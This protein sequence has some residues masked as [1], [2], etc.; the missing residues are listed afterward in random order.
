MIK[1]RTE[2]VIT[3]QDWDELVEATYGRPYSFQQQDGCRDRG[4]VSLT[5]P[6]E[7][8]E[9]YDFQNDTVPEIVNHE[10]RGVSFKAWL[11]RDPQQKLDANTNKWDSPSSL[12]LWWD[13]NHYPVIEMVAN[14][15]Y[16]KGLI[17]AG[18]YSIDVDW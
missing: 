3:V 15:L 7:E 12:R 5:V 6:D 13:R 1:T 2:K 10:D 14:D 4:R 16:R 18:E 17:E 9:S 11:Q 8:A